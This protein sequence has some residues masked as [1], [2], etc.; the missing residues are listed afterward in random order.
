ME[1]IG[2]LTFVF[3]TV[4]LAGVV[5]LLLYFLGSPQGNDASLKKAVHFRGIDIKFH[6]L[7]LFFVI[8]CIQALLLFPWM[9][10]FDRE[11]TWMF[12]FLTSIVIVSYIF[13]WVSEGLDW[14]E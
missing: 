12:L 8:L 4:L 10:N 6:Q 1:I 9:I 3:L 11:N 13:V 5:T 2:L 7:I 14:K